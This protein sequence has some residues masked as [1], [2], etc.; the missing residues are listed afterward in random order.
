MQ[1]VNDWIPYLE[2]LQR[3]FGVKRYSTIVKDLLQLL[4]AS[5]KDLPSRD[6][7][8]TWLENLDSEGVED[9]EVDLD[10]LLKLLRGCL[11]NVSVTIPLHPTR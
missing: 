5:P 7:W 10:A 4:R 3:Q 2:M 9:K 8:M 11:K 6:A 1:T